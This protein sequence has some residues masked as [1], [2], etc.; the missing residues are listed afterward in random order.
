MP[1]DLEPG[2]PQRKRTKYDD[3]IEN[4]EHMPMPG[5]TW[6]SD[7]LKKIDM[8]RQTGYNEEDLPPE[9]KVDRSFIKVPHH[10]LGK[11]GYPVGEGWLHPSCQEY[12]QN[13]KGKVQADQEEISNSKLQPTTSLLSSSQVE[14]GGKQNTFAEFIASVIP[15]SPLKAIHKDHSSENH[16]GKIILQPTT[17]S[18]SAMHPGVETK[19]EPTEPPFQTMSKRVAA[20]L[21]SL[22]D[23]DHGL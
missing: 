10:L 1:T 14:V 5:V 12:L 21:P 9:F 23:L 19:A 4:S 22:Y 17:S 15:T 18:S 13:G 6:L 11:D 16:V 2:W 3:R 7:Y 8:K 20:T